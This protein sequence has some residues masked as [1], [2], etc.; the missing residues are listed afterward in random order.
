MLLLGTRDWAVQ[1]EMR[2]GLRLGIRV[3]KSTAGGMDVD[4]R[5]GSGLSTW[6]DSGANY[7]D[8]VTGGQVWRVRDECVNK[9][10]HFGNTK[11]DVL[12]TVKRPAQAGGCTCG[13]AGM[14]ETCPVPPAGVR[15]GVRPRG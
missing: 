11:C 2:M 4:M 7:G 6:V 12:E 9:T 14:M 15:L 13:R 3:A 1:V 5:E 8:G 10:L